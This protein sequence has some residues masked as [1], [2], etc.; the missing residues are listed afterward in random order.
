MGRESLLEIVEAIYRDEANDQEWM[1]GV[2]GAARDTLNFGMG[3]V[4][5]PFDASQGGVRVPWVAEVGTSKGAGADLVLEIMATA[6]EDSRV[7]DVWRMPLC[8]TGSE[9]GLT[10]HPSW[11]I[12]G[13]KGIADFLAL[14]GVDTDGRGCL[15]GGF[16]PR[17][18]SIHRHRRAKLSRVVTHLTVG[19]R[20]RRQVRRAGLAPEAVFDGASKLV[21]AQGEATASSAR[22]ALAHAVKALDRARGPAGRRAPDEALEAWKGL[23]AGRWSLV[24]SF[25]S[26]GRRYVVATENE[27]VTPSIESLSKRERQVAVYAAAGHPSKLI[28]YELGIADSTVRVLLGRAMKRLRVESRRAL[29]EAIVRAAP[30]PASDG[31]S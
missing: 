19:Y 16:L 18:E 2:V 28:A 10:S 8:H 27:P 23:V 4:G 15:I 31:D 25:E 17:V 3:V 24:D 7:S 30:K 11:R 14:N 5:M 12:L 26:D 13:Q 9:A 22:Q 6:R 29:A 20:Y 21:H 1:R